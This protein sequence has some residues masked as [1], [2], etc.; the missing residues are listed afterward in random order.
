M[1]LHNN[2]AL[3][4]DIDGKDIAAAGGVSTEIK[5]TLKRL[6]INAETVRRVSIAMY[7]A[8]INTVIHGGGGK[9][10][11]EI[12]PNKFAAVF[13]DKGPGIPDIEL[14]MQEGYST[15]SDEAIRMGFGAG[16]GLANIN[17]HADKLEITSEV[18]IGT[19]VKI[20]ATF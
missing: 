1:E 14:A 20:E 4:Y 13:T 5:Q 9:V 2:L 7:E 3:T 15:A 6:G 8:E 16:M 18:G 11:I 10:D 17:K 12:Q 19:T